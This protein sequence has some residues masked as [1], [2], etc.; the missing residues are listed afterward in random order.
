MTSIGLQLRQVRESDRW[1]L[2]E[3][4]NSERIRRISVHDEEIPRSD[5]DAW[6]T[7]N[8]PLMRDRTVIV[9]WNGDAVGWYQIEKWDESSRSGEWGIA[10]GEAPTPVGLGGSLPLLALSHAFD[11]LN[12][13][14]MTGRVLNLNT[15]MLSIMRRLRI[16]VIGQSGPLVRQ[17][18][19]QTTMTVYRVDRAGW[20]EILEG[21]LA[22]VPSSLR[23]SI[24]AVLSA[25]LGE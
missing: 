17:D 7:K 22:M 23:S 16:P 21:G 14:R 25:P 10:L 1:T 5:H 8:F 3:W 18:G 24:R 19:T 13:S 9:E 15:N 12:A 4:R 11:R 2:W 20:P 6:F